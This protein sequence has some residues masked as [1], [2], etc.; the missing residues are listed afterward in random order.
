[1]S[2]RL[3][4]LPSLTAAESARRWVDNVPP[5]AGALGVL[6]VVIVCALAVVVWR[7]RRAARPA[8]AA[9]DAEDA[10]AALDGDDGEM[11][12]FAEIVTLRQMLA[13]LDDARESGA[14][15]KG[16]YGRR[17]SLL[18]RRLRELEGDAE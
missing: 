4:E 12:V 2:V 17:R 8:P 14:L 9:A 15:G 18:E 16:D 10:P 13:D 7:R 6:G 3:S 11:G 5:E 1:M